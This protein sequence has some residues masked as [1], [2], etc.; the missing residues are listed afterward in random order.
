MSSSRRKTRARAIAP[1]STYLRELPLELQEEL[2]VYQTGCPLAVNIEPYFGG[3]A[4]KGWILRISFLPPGPRAGETYNLLVFPGAIRYSSQRMTRFGPEAVD[5]FLS[6]PREGILSLSP[7]TKV[8]P[9]DIPD[10]VLV[11]MQRYQ[12]G[13][14]TTDVPIPLCRNFIDGLLEAT[15]FPRM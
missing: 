1:P 2:F 14:E 11:R 10:Y 3:G 5:A 13:P 7:E 4:D 8:I 12:Y 9:S 15:R 6:H